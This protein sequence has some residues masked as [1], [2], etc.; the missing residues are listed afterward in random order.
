MTPSARGAT[1]W[2]AGAKFPYP[3]IKRPSAGA[4]GAGLLRRPVLGPKRGRMLPI[5]WSR[6][7][8]G[9]VS[10]ASGQSRRV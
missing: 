7:T 1:R 10:E 4:L 5:L 9:P 3:S 6:P 8:S 2:P